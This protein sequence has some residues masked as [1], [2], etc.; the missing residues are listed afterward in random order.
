MVLHTN[1]R[2]VLQVKGTNSC[3][4]AGLCYISYE[5]GFNPP[6]R[7][8]HYENSETSE[9]TLSPPCNVINVIEA[10]DLRR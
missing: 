8:F 4:M 2:A 7:D 1:S 9:L 10:E 6:R 3:D 5:I